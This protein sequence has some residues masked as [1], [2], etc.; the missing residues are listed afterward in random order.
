MREWFPVGGE[1]RD[2]DLPDPEQPNVVFASGLGGRITRWN[3]LTGVVENVSPWPIM[4]SYGKRPTD[5]QYHYNW[6]SPI[7]FSKQKPYALY[8]GAQVLFRSLDRGTHWEVISPAL[9]GQTP[10]THDC[11]GDPTPARALECG[12]GSIN[13]IA[14]APHDNAEIWIGTDDGRVTL[15]RDGGTHWSTVTPRDAPSWGKV[16]SIDLSAAGRGIVYV[17]YDNHRQDDVRPYVYRTRDYGATW[18]SIGA[19]LPSDHFVSVVRSDPVR[20]GLLY[21]GTEIGVQVSFDDGASWQSLSRR[22]PPVW[23]HDLIVKDRD[24]VV[25][26]NGRGLWVLDDV[27]PLRQLDLAAAHAPR[28]YSPAPAY[29]VRR[30][31]NKDTPLAP[32][33]PQGRNPP[34]GAVIDYWLPAAAKGPVDLEV[35]DASGSVVRRFSSAATTGEPEAEVY[36]D[37]SWLVPGSRLSAAS[38]PHRFV[39]D[40]RLERPRAINYQYDIAATVADG[41]ELLPAGPLA[42]PGEYRLTLVVDGVRV[43][44]PLRVV[45]DPRVQVATADLAAGVRFA[46]E[47][48]SDLA[49]VWRGYAELGAVKAQI[50]ARRA[51]LGAAPREV[52]L[53]GQLDALSAAIEPL[54]SG[55]REVTPGFGLLGLT[56]ANLATDVEGADRAP[57]D[58]QRELRKAVEARLI[59]AIGRWGEVRAHELAAVNQALAANKLARIAIPDAAH[60]TAT[61][62]PGSEDQ[63]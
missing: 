8:A 26:T 12:Y 47:L 61:E 58:G 36:F 41:T 9:N 13:V 44:A 39:W 28:L 24:L 7:A 62:P 11:D 37:R 59:A 10:G 54:V 19:G 2:Y 35:R 55:P 50:A 34:T 27:T 53:A 29:R 4:S 57:T 6:F 5:Y 63:P 52:A 45:P 60:L 38:G 21:A 31:A 1:E 48:A 42:L 20:A 22:L 18:T 16:S 3:S 33:T 17:A 30:N 56:L 49:Q 14:P 51:S 46:T 15:T 43:D 40:L 25:A 23:V 32:E